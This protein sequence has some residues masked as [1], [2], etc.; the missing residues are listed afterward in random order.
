M[1]NGT[2]GDHPLTDIL[3]H[4]VEVYGR[5]AD[6]T[7]RKISELCSWRELV[8]W[9][10]RQ[11]AWS[12]DTHLVL[13]KS[14]SRLAELLRRAK[15]AGGKSKSERGFECNRLVSSV[16]SIE[17]GLVGAEMLVEANFPRKPTFRVRSDELKRRELSV[18][19][20]PER[21]V[22]KSPVAARIHSTELACV[23]SQK[24]AI[25]LAIGVFLTFSDMLPGIIDDLMHDLK[26]KA[27]DDYFGV[28]EVLVQPQ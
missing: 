18:S 6:E 4:K 27:E 7:I 15:E 10:D 12:S 28:F 16:V 19:V 20:I 3:F 23:V 1:P 13:A 22:E 24:V 5:E 11:I 2:V 17:H 8:K 21:V 14:K 9:W 25:S 26:I